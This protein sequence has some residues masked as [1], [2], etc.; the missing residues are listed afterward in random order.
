M[1]QRLAP[2]LATAWEEEKKKCRFTEDCLN[3]FKCA[4]W[5]TELKFSTNSTSYLST[6]LI[7]SVQRAVVIQ[8]T[9]IL[10]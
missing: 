9:R 7:L 10:S 2:T 1:E 5:Y 8:P 4:L 3:V 6:S